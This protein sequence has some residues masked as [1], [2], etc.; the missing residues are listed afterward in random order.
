MKFWLYFIGSFLSGTAL[1]LSQQKSF[2][3]L[4]GL[5]AIGGMCF[6]LENTQNKWVRFTCV[7]L[8]FLAYIV[9]TFCFL[10]HAAPIANPIGL[11]L[12]FIPYVIYVIPM[13]WLFFVN[14]FIIE[15]FLIS[16]LLS[17][18]VFLRI[19][20]GNPFLQIGTSLSY[21]PQ[22]IQWYQYTG[23]LGG[24]LWLLASVYALYRIF[25]T[26][27]IHYSGLAIILIPIVCSLTLGQA[28]DETL[29]KKAIGIVSLDS[30]N[31][32]IDS[33]LMT[34]KNEARLDYIL[35]PEAIWSFVE[36]SFEMHP[37]MTSIRRSLNDSLQNALLI[38]GI[39]MYSQEIGSQNSVV[40]YS[41]RSAPIFRYKQRY[42]PFGEYVP[43]PNVLGRISFLHNFVPYN[44]TRHKNE[45][46]LFIIHQDTI[47]PLICYEGLFL[48][49]LSKLCRSGA[50][51]LL[52]SA[53]NIMLNS[54]HI[55]K[56]ICNISIGN[57]IS[58]KRSIA[59]AT[60]NGLSY[61]INPHGRL[62]AI[63]EQENT[64]LKQ[65]IPLLSQKT[66][67]CKYDTILNILYG[68]GYFLA[69]IYLIIAA[70][71]N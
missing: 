60:S 24:S 59:R 45:S 13:L 26:K 9:L 37:H 17:E 22:F 68:I 50:E 36:G 31:T 34:N 3:F 64:L 41:R 53:S 49:E 65:H 15:L 14:R 28:H 48:Q 8:F 46:E 21:V 52:I 57:A 29:K 33:I 58:M 54:I 16:W 39:F 5:F 7:N 30:Y 70:R 56:L 38:M 12:V 63:S 10:A 71:A 42:I 1:Y 27:N 61:F 66:F 20:I 23:P 43:Y 44:L 25:V 18:W 4:I 32:K 67:Y 62:I 11:L 51:I 69:M 6:L 55:E 47:A 2:F 19:E 35:C 40:A